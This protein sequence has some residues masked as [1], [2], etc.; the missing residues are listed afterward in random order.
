MSIMK[1]RDF[2]FFLAGVMG[3]FAVGYTICW[4]NRPLPQLV[5]QD[6]RPVTQNP[7]RII[8]QTGDAINRV[9]PVLQ[10]IA[11]GKVPSPLDIYNL[12]QGVN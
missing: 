5:G 2:G 9:K 3:G 6:G 11:S 8:L 10:P 1:G 4:W 12:A 7:A